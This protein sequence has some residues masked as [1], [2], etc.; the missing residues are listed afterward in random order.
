[1]SVDKRFIA[2]AEKDIRRNENDIDECKENITA[3]QAAQ[4]AMKKARKLVRQST[5]RELDR[6]VLTVTW[7]ID[8]LK[9]RIEDNKRDIK[10]TK[11][12]IAD[13][14]KNG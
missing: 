10:D 2:S 8:D 11:E 6:C 14:K 9:E 3:L 12:E 4:K 13:E 1:M 5:A 7:T